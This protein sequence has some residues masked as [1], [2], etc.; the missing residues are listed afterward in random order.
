[1]SFYS[2]LNIP[3]SSSTEEIMVAYRRQVGEL[4]RNM[5]IAE[6][7]SSDIGALLIK[8]Q[9]LREA[10]DVLCDPQQRKSYDVFRKTMSQDQGLPNDHEDLWSIMKAAIV[11]RRIPNALELI[12]ELTKLE[13]D[14]A[15]LT[16]PEESQSYDDATTTS[17]LPEQNLS[18]PNRPAARNT[19]KVSVQL[20]PKSTPP[21]HDEESGQATEPM[22][23][24]PKSTPSSKA[25]ASLSSIK[26]PRKSNTSDQNNSLEVSTTRTAQRQR[27]ISMKSKAQGA[28]V[29]DRIEASY[30]RYGHD[31]RFLQEVRTLRGMEIEHLS[32]STMVAEEYILAIENNSYDTLPAEIFTRNYLKRI[33]S[34]LNIADR[35]IVDDYLHLYYNR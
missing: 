21:L 14:N 22:L 8:S 26:T 34:A 13:L 5:R 17:L 12:A 16:V 19:P 32:R 29:Q 7:E 23:K 10:K 18:H 2:M 35:S 9:Q 11:D 3:D 15:S 20:E 6:Q 30:E 33:A 1:M 28:I 4:V 24:K 27:S 31:G 25:S